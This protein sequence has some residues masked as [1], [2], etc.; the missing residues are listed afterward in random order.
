M[1]KGNGTKKAIPNV[2]LPRKKRRNGV[3][4]DD[5]NSFA[6]IRF[7]AGNRIHNSSCSNLSAHDL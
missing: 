2:S 6:L 5:T 4:F 7:D 3:K 1:T